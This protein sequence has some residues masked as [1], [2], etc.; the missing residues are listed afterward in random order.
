M[1]AFIDAFKTE[2]KYVMCCSGSGQAISDVIEVLTETFDLLTCWVDPFVDG[3]MSET[4]DVVLGAVQV[5]LEPVND[6]IGKVDQNLEKLN[7][8]S[9]RL[10][11][12]GAIFTMPKLEFYEKDGQCALSVFPDKWG[13]LEF[14]E[15]GFNFE[16]GNE[17]DLDADGEFSFQE[18]GTAIH[19][20]CAA[21]A[22]DFAT[23]SDDCCLLARLA[24]GID[25]GGK[26]NYS[27][28][29]WSKECKSC[30][31][32]ATGNS[33]KCLLKVEGCGR[34]S[35]EDSD[36]LSG[37]CGANSCAK[38]NNKICNGQACTS[39]NQCDSGRCDVTGNGKKCLPKLANGSKCN[40]NSDC[41]SSKCKR[42][43]RQGRR[44]E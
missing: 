14:V 30:R 38:S 43:R 41:Q 9:I 23:P 16:G 27:S 29:A 12:F 18:I 32:D 13:E 15:F 31:C 25:P 7:D 44:C 22:K 4:L 42:R 35:G 11:D 19:E 20:N 40:E 8:V 24:K 17:L 33:K 10:P 2:S 3:V 39:S 28:C 37:S 34:C 5:L 1:S 6:I 36:C 21:A 26:P